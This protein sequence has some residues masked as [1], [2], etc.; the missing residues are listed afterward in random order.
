MTSPGEALREAVARRVRALL[1]KTTENGASEAEAIAAAE[2]ARQLLDAHRLTQ[3]DCEIEAE[4]IEDIQIDRPNNLKFAAV[5]YCLPGIDAYCGVKTWFHKRHGIRRVRMIGLKSDTEMAVYLYRLI[6]N[7]IQLESAK[8]MRQ[9][10][11]GDATISRRLRQSF[12]I[13]MS[14]RVNQR[15]QDMA[16]ALEPTARTATG[17]ALVVVKTQVV[18]AAFDRLGLKLGKGLDGMRVRARD[19]YAEGRV[20]G[21]RVNL[22][23]PLD[24]R[25]TAALTNKVRT[26]NG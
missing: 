9:K 19:A 7:T 8:F 20:A 21:D 4:P 3:A 1:A 17:T 2:K 6:A 26:A 22:S 10:Q 24:A 16:K 5:D 11:T 25:Y 13:G 23:Q 15:L 14:G 12:Q 18:D